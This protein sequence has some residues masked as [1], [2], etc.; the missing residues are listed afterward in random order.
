M[1]SESAELLAWQNQAPVELSASEEEEEDAQV[2]TTDTPFHDMYTIV[3]NIGSGTYGSVSKVVRVGDDPKNPLHWSAAK[4]IKTTR[5]FN[6]II[7]EFVTSL[8]LKSLGRPAI[9]NI[10]CIHDVYVEKS[11]T[12]IVSDYAGIALSDTRARMMVLV[13]N[14]RAGILVRL[15]KDILY[16]LGVLHALGIAHRDI[17]PQNIAISTAIPN[18][19]TTQDVNS[20]H[21]SSSTTFSLIDMGLASPVGS[22]P[23]NAIRGTRL[24]LGVDMMYAIDTFRADLW[25]LG[26]T[27][28]TLMLAPPFKDFYLASKLLRDKGVDVHMSELELFIAIRHTYNTIRDELVRRDTKV[29]D[30]FSLLQVPLADCYRDKK[31]LRMM[32]SALLCVDS[33]H[34][35]HSLFP[36]HFSSSTDHLPFLGITRTNTHVIDDDD[37]HGLVKSTYTRDAKERAVFTMDQLLQSTLQ[38][39]N[40]KQQR[41]LR[42]LLNVYTG[43]TRD[44]TQ[45]ELRQVV[46]SA[47]M[48]NVSL[49]C[50]RIAHRQKVVNIVRGRFAGKQAVVIGTNEDGSYRVCIKRY[51]SR[52]CCT[53]FEAVSRDEILN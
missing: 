12:Y 28:I 44:I 23:N 43:L 36:K 31:E 45:D 15:V 1:S 7:N 3:S 40:R 20:V 6:G 49:V 37:I 5:D 53:R 46:N 22:L 25:G 48:H 42:K 9:G 18:F 13:S 30:V 14:D 8:L 10:Q 24:F 4:T 17:K 32:V 39:F 2:V 29:V 33:V 51:E 19:D 26:V 50:K 35:M 47:C 11:N 21:M 34:E 16:A 52:G 38:S 41:I 27:V